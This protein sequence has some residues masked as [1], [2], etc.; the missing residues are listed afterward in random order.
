MLGSSGFNI[1]RRRVGR[2]PRTGLW[3]P[4]R[5][6]VEGLFAITGLIPESRPLEIVQTSFQWN[7][8]TFLNIGFVGVFAYLY[9]L[10]RHRNRLGGGRGHAYDPVCGMQVRAAN[11]PA[12]TQH[13][14][15]TVYFC[16]DRCRGRFEGEP[17][18]Y[19]E[20]ASG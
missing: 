5:Q 13:A 17:D 20:R 8:T 14:G 19:A 6:T 2:A 4:K 11:A 9:W 16:S 7:Y 3:P 1:V 12:S 15:R 10:Y 18:R